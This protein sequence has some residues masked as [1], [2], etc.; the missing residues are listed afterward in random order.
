MATPP[1]AFSRAKACSAAA[2]VA[3]CAWSLASAGTA[4]TQRDR[5]I[6][7]A[8]PASAPLSAAPTASAGR[9]ASRSPVTARAVDI[10]T[11]ARAHSMKPI[12]AATSGAP[13]A[14][15]RS[16]ASPGGRRST[17]G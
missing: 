11:S 12:Q 16:S 14:W 15:N 8:R 7:W 1:Q 2:R 3:G 10:G 4:K 13:P 5:P 6:A 9:S 17:C